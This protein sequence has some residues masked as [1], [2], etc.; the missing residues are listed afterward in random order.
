MHTC[1]C[2][3]T[4]MELCR[5]PLCPFCRSGGEGKWVGGC[6]GATLGLGSVV[7]VSKGSAVPSF[8]LR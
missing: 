3:C 6:D 8:H 1:V 5:S 7:K 2:V 4:P